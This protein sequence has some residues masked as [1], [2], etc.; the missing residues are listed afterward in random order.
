MSVG[1]NFVMSRSDGAPMRT[2]TF[3]GTRANRTVARQASI[4]TAKVRFDAFIVQA[5]VAVLGAE[6][7][8]GIDLTGDELAAFRES[9]KFAD[10]VPQHL[11]SRTVVARNFELASEDRRR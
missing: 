2:W 4:G 6:L 3:A 5:P 7:P 10:C 1:T 9:I 11:L 8:A